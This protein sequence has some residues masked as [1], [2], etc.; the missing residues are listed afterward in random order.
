MT[1]WVEKVK[2]AMTEKG[3]NQKELAK[4]SGITE[5]SVSRYLKGERTPRIDII[6]NF[7]KV[8]DLDIN[9]LLD[10]HSVHSAYEDISIAIARRGNELNEEEKNKLILLLKN[11]KETDA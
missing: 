3:M 2:K 9:E 4:Y 8:L 6:T 1:T 7:A 10:T 11:G 5:P